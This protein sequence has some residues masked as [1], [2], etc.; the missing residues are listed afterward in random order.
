MEKVGIIVT[1]SSGYIGT[2]LIKK[3]SKRNLILC[4]RESFQHHETKLFDS[5][6][7]IIE[8]ISNKY[9]SFVIIHLA[10]YFSKK[11]SDNRLIKEANLDFGFKLIDYT[12]ELHI[13]KI[14]YTNTMFNFYNDFSIRNLE[15]TKTKAEFS[16]YLKE[17]AFNKNI[18]YDEIFLDSTF[19]GIDK[20]KKIIPLIVECVLNNKISPVLDKNST[21]NLIYYQDVIDRILKSILSNVHGSSSFINTNSINTESIYKYLSH[22]YKNNLQ[23]SNILSYIPNSYTPK[24]PKVNYLDIKISKIE[25]KLISYL[26]QFQLR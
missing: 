17:Y 25:D 3:I 24:F 16:E 20:R 15:Y 10:T 19:G 6:N 23:K 2:Q 13:K 8:K 14:I 1:G 7:N 12:K 21:L 18:I 11:T 26:N 9:T 22:Y 5:E 4:T